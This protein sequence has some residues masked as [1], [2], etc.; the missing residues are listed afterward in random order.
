MHG[1]HSP[2]ATVLPLLIQQPGKEQAE[3]KK[4]ALGWTCPAHAKKGGPNAAALPISSA[5]SAQYL[6]QHQQSP[7]ETPSANT[8][9]CPH[10]RNDTS[11]KLPKLC[12]VSPTCAGRPCAPTRAWT[13]TPNSCTAGSKIS[14]GLGE[15]NLWLKPKPHIPTSRPPQGGKAASSGAI[16]A[17]TTP[18]CS[19]WNRVVKC[20]CG[21]LDLRRHA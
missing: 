4:Q 20:T 11:R 21:P 13:K 6:T 5:L 15:L 9:P 2:T 7:A 18:A 14:K 12:S 8:Q 16:S 19:Q 1:S 17:A 10:L 3:N